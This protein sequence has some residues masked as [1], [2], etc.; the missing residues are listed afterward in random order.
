MHNVGERRQILLVEDNPVNQR[1]ATAML[2]HLCFHAD[3]V[4]DGAEAVKAATLKTYQAILMDCQIPV[5][6]G[7]QATGEI[8]RLPGGSRRAPI[9]AV[10]ASAL[11]SDRQRC[12]DAGMDDFLLKPLSLKALAEVLARWA[13][14]G[15]EPAA[16]ARPAEVLA[17]THVGPAHAVEPA[18]AVLNAEVIGRLERLGKAAG[19]DLKG[20]VAVL[21]LAD[22]DVRVVAL[23]EALAEDDAA[24]VVR[25]AHTLSGASSNVG[26]TDLARLCATLETAGVA[27]DLLGGGAMLD[28]VEAELGQVRSALG[29]ATPTP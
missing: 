5:L 4:N 26:A 9:I 25:A 15:S 8:R 28:A 16:H 24:A 6:D 22:A 3:V 10:T 18:R 17:A 1:V 19:E 14:D 29:A 13:P 20:Q 12:L 2:E 23:R 27:G 7:Y 21:F 11:E